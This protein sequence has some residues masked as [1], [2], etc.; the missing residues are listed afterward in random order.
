LS[1]VYR[2]IKE[3][4][5]FPAPLKQFC[6]LHYFE[7]IHAAKSALA[8]LLG[9]ALIQLT[10]NPEPHRQWVLV[11]IAVVMDTHTVAGIHAISAPAK[12]RWYF[13]NI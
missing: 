10:E 12:H 4:I 8:L 3:N 5:I 6:H 11:S 13:H 2:Q 7:L 1:E 9:Y